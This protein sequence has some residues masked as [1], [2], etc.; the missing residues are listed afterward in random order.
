MLYGGAGGM[1]PVSP[2]LIHG[3]AVYTQWICNARHL[4]R[5]PAIH[6]SGSEMEMWGKGAAKEFIYW[7]LET[8]CCAG[9]TC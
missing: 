9:R 1:D 7:I 5:E 6:Y 4:S 8:L 3:G 2:D